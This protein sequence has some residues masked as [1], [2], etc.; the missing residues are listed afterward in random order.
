MWLDR[1]CKGTTL[2]S[3]AP[4]PVFVS[5]ALFPGHWTG[6]PPT[7][8]PCLPTHSSL[9]PFRRSENRIS[10]KATFINNENK[11]TVESS[12]IFSFRELLCKSKQC[13]FCPCTVPNPVPGG[14]EKRYV[15]GATERKPQ[16]K[17]SV[18]RTRVLKRTHS[19]IRCG[20]QRTK[21][22]PVQ[23]LKQHIILCYVTPRP[24]C[25]WACMQL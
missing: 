13:L 8:G 1:G 5:R 2:L 21:P 20:I 3:I 12:K 15:K 19:T 18:H 23:I 7:C 11:I 25:P 24:G 4:S 10:L 14:H 9:A 22:T 16:E 17:K 6:M